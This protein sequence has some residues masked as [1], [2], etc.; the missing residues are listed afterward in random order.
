LRF[1]DL[2]HTTASLLMMGGA[3]PAAVQRILRHSD[4][5]ITTEVYGHLAP[6][7]LRDEIERLRF[8]V[9]P[10]KLAPTSA[11]VETTSVSSFA[12]IRPANRVVTSTARRATS[13]SDA[14][15]GPTW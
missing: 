4:P 13:R 8:G 6:G 14:P 9:S 10:D 5:K 2:R 3:N 11:T 1:H 7:Y 12:G 15:R